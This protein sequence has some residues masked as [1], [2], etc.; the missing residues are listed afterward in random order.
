MKYDFVVLRRAE[1]DVRHLLHWIAERSIQG[2]NA[3]LDAYEQLIDRLT[4][5]AESFPAALEMMIVRL[6]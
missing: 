4:A 1:G 6:R 2:A 5:D 3:W